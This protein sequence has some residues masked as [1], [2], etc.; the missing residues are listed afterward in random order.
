ML[1]GST[2]SA[3]GLR[4]TLGL[5]EGLRFHDGEPVLAKDCVASLRRWGQVDSFGQALLAATEGLTAEGERAI[6]F[7]LKRPFPRLPAAL[8]QVTGFVASVLP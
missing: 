5:R 4:W 7:S 6:V 1:E 8:A 3:D 2:T